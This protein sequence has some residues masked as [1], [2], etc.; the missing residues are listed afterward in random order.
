MPN[1]WQAAALVEVNLFLS[2]SIDLVALLPRQSRRS[3][4]KEIRKNRSLSFRADTLLFEAIFLGHYLPGSPACPAPVRS[5]KWFICPPEQIGSRRLPSSGRI[6]K[7]SRFRKPK[8]SKQQEPISQPDAC[9]IACLQSC[10]SSSQHP[11]N[12]FYT[13]PAAQPAPTH[14]GTNAEQP[15]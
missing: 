2:R 7:K 10:P 5:G 9:L 14:C 1:T 12:H 6:P 3:Y 15:R 13:C 4:S 11:R 8:L